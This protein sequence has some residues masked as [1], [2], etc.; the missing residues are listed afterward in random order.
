MSKTALFTSSFQC[1]FATLLLFSKGSSNNNNVLYTSQ[2][3]PISTTALTK[4]ENIT[5]EWSS[6]V[7]SHKTHFQSSI[8]YFAAQTNQ[9]FFIKVTNFTFLRKLKTGCAYCA[10]VVLESSVEILSYCMPSKHDFQPQNTVYSLKE[11]LMLV[12]YHKLYCEFQVKI[13]VNTT[14]CNTV[15]LDACLVQKLK[16][17]LDVYGSALCHSY[18]GDLFATSKVSLRFQQKEKEGSLIPRQKH[19]CGEHL[20]TYHHLYLSVPEGYCSVIQISTKKNA[21]FAKRTDQV[22][23]FGI[24]GVDDCHFSLHLISPHITHLFN[25]STS[26]SYR[27]RGS[28]KQIRRTS[29]SRNHCL[30]FRGFRSSETMV[31]IVRSNMT[32]NSSDRFG[33][34]GPPLPYPPVHTDSHFHFHLV[35][36]QIMTSTANIID[37]GI[38]VWSPAW[39]DLVIWNMSSN[40]TFTKNWEDQSNLLD[41]LNEHSKLKNMPKY[42]NVALQIMCNDRTQAGLRKKDWHKHLFKCQG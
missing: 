40:G 26:L 29:V 14:V 3:L 24:G 13:Y 21:S 38:T 15:R 31:N 18:L 32:A 9:N 19:V 33:D 27:V 10:A 7:S 11:T 41:M 8:Y 22:E 35:A 1:L 16:M 28:F 4:Q 34:K 25:P 30:R 5:L 2:L 36:K 17:C 37:V 20:V 12:V 39:I 6:N 42:E 23:P